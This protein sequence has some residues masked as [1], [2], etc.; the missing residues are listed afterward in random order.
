ASSGGGW[1][2]T[3][4]RLSVAAVRKLSCDADLIPAVLGSHGEV[5]DL[6][7][8]RR[9]VTFA[10]FLAL[11]IRDRHCSFPG[12]RRPPIMCDAHHIK[13]WADG[14]PTRLDN[15]A[16]LCRAHHTVIHQTGWQ[17]RIN[18]HDQ[19]PEFLPPA[20]LRGERQ[21]VRDRHPREER[22]RL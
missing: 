1:L 11:V 2:D 21:W 15:L 8:T 7:H 9:L 12:C 14:G 3:G 22:E 19:R 5:L 20:H 13:H 10:L 17:I 16:L 4:E 6:G 18:P